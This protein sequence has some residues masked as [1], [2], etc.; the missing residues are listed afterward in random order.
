MKH[1]GI[2]TVPQSIATAGTPIIRW[3]GARLLLRFGA[4]EPLRLKPKHQAYLG[5]P[6]RNQD[7]P[8]GT[9]LLWEEGKEDDL[10]KHKFFDCTQRFLEELTAACRPWQPLVVGN[11]FVWQSGPYV[12]YAVQRGGLIHVGLW[13]TAAPVE[14]KYLIRRPLA[15]GHEYLRLNDAGDVMGLRCD[16]TPCPADMKASDDLKLPLQWE[17]Y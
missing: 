3:W 6:S 2:V 8:E 10:R 7:R 4:Q 16:A 11:E 17:L 9:R 1:F 15:I 5:P 12:G 14:L 13:E